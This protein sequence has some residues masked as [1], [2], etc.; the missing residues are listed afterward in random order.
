MDHISQYS[1]AC[2]AKCRG[3]ILVDWF[4]QSLRRMFPFIHQENDSSKLGGA[5]GIHD[6]C[7][8]MIPGARVRLNINSLFSAVAK[9]LGNSGGKDTHRNAIIIKI[10]LPIS[11]NTYDHGVLSARPPHGF[12]MIDRGKI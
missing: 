10:N 9:G 1:F 8:G 12:W 3:P 5:K 6:V 7:H 2:T 4:R 11:K